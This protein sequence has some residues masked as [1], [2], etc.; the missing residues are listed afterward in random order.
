M[1]V[2]E[3]GTWLDS[4][5]CMFC[6]VVPKSLTVTRLSFPAMRLKIA[7]LHPLVSVLLPYIHQ[8]IIPIVVH[9]HPNVKYTAVTERRN[10]T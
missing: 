7:K 6:F 9:S 8:V 4:S 2:R 3:D 5:F 10:Q 1:S